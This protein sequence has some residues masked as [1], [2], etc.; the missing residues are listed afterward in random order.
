MYVCYVDESGTPEV[1]GTTSHFVLA[2][3]SV[4]IN[5]WREADS[6]ISAILA[7]YDLFGKEFHTA[8]LLRKYQEQAQ[9]KNFDALD[10]ASRRREVER[11]RNAHLLAL[12]GRGQHKAFRQAKK[13][14]NHTKDYIHLTFAQR[15]EL[16]S[17]IADC[18]GKWQFAT[19]FAECIDKLW[20]DP[21]RTG[22]SVSE[23]A[24]EQVVSRFE[25]FLTRNGSDVY[26]LLVHDNN[27]TIAKKHTELM[28]HFHVQGTLWTAISHIIE[29]PL[30]VDSA[31]TGMVQVA[32][33][34][35]YSLRRYAEKQ[36]KDLLRR[37]F[38][39]ADAVNGIAVG[40]RHF[41]N[42]RCSCEICEKHRY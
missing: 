25:Q 11:K 22:R 29:T 40:V 36:E 16:V 18:V 19:L 21:A 1:P 6:Q 32:D 2:G 42:P 30:F 13:T 8:W 41:T 39:R 33:L 23:Q 10:T 4:P 37:L 15:R 26:G 38:P 34:W 17:E 7:R 28:R 27:E 12:Q 9:I 31:L 20:F 14:Y 5:H 24:F 3:V 35:A